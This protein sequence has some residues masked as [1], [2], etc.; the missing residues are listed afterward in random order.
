MWDK[1]NFKINQLSRKQKTMLSS[2]M[3]FCNQFVTIVCGFILPRFFLKYYGSDVNGLVSSIT[4]FL[5]F[6]SLA[7]L[8]VGAVVRS[9][10]YK[11]LANKDVDQISRVYLSSEHFFRKLALLLVIYVAV[12]MV[13]YP[14]IAIDSFDYIYSASLILII[15]IS[16]FFQFFVGMSYKLLIS[17]DQ[18]ASIILILQ[19]LSMLLKTVFSII[20][21]RLSFSVHAVKFVSSI[22]LIIQP[23][24]LAVFAK[25][26]YKINRKIKLEGEPIK[27]KWN[28]LAQH[29]AS[30][31]LNNT[32]VTV[33]TLFS[34]LK[35][36]SVYAIYYMVLSGLKSLVDSFTNG[37]GAL[38]GDLYARS[39]I[40][41]LNNTFSKLEWMIH[42]STVL[43]YSIAG[44]TIIPFVTVYTKGV[45]DAVYYQPL[46][47]IILLLAQ[48]VCC[49][50]IPS[51]LLICSAG[52]FKQTQM[53]AII[54]AFINIVISVITVVKFGLVGVAI[55]TLS[56]MIYRTGYYVWY[57]SKNILVRNSKS[58]FKILAVDVLCV[59]CITLVR[60]LIP[61]LFMMSG[62][63]YFSW[64]V[65][66]AKSGV[67]C[68]VIVT[69]INIVFYPKYLKGL[70]DRIMVVY[71]R[72]KLS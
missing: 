72:R 49:L 15:S 30:V 50:R 46:F 13:V 29:I 71:K 69:S 16:M 22:I 10:L 45:T 41:S 25:H 44:L 2:L 7:E 62:T 20:L 1:V 23:L 60:F 42:Y 39:E 67:V 57:L 65:L 48:V 47:A 55:G 61:S 34:T 26:R 32:D 3:S 31:V 5:G 14:L 52:H 68:I 12:L 27:Q 59:L 40:D 37:F 8:G 58:F 19:C 53:S 35:N 66:A 63:D 28:G 36:V 24:T 70:W 6:I 54:E 11:P 56:A 51:H 43:I 17:A 64:F 18:L 38:M 33:L 9:A 4:Q 21:I